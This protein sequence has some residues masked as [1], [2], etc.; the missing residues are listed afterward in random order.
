MK[1]VQ[2][3]SGLG[4]LS[5]QAR[6]T[7][8]FS[9]LRCFHNGLKHIFLFSNSFPKRE[10]F[11]F[12]E[13]TSFGTILLTLFSSLKYSAAF[14][15]THQPCRSHEHLSR[16]CC[17]LLPGQSLPGGAL[18]PQIQERAA[19]SLGW[20]K[21]GGWLPPKR[22]KEC[23]QVKIVSRKIDEHSEKLNLMEDTQYS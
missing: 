20:S 23:Q 7:M 1:V 12:R 19:F 4:L 21:G 3:I 22:L 17:L 14:L 10:T 2:S 11:Y 5:M 8:T 13:F 15:N 16:M 6:E 18:R 9:W